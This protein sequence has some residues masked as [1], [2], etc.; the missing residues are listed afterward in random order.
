MYMTFLLCVCAT[1]LFK[2][3]IFTDNNVVSQFKKTEHHE[4]VYKNTIYNILN[5]DNLFVNF[6]IIKLRRNEN[7]IR[8]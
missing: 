7:G 6:I 4:Y 3:S 2:F 5:M 8:I 1:C